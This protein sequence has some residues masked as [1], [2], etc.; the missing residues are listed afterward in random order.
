MAPSLNYILRMTAWV[1]RFIDKLKKQGE[2]LTGPL[3]VKKIQK[4]KLL[5]ELHIQQ[6]HYVDTIHTVN[7]GKKSNLNSQL[8][9]DQNGL[10]RCHGG[11]ENVELNQAAKCP[12]LIPKEGHFTRLVVKDIHSQVLHSRVSQTLAKVQQEH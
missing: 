7:H 9:L 1:L 4:A 11:F 5:C 10:L 8:I 2:V 3:T 6:K 12:K